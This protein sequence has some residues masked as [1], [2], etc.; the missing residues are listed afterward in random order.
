MRAKQPVILDRRA[1][2]ELLRLRAAVERQS[3]V[4]HSTQL[5]LELS[6][7]HW[8]Q[9]VSKVSGG[10]FMATGIA[11]ATQYPYL[12]SALSSLLIKKRWRALKWAGVALA[13]WQTIHQVKQNKRR[14]HT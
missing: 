4:V 14:Q 6:P 9:K 12:T 13:I 1:H 10:Q 3:L 8:L 7:K 11:L 5:K 2:L